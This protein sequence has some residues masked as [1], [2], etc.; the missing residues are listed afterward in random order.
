LGEQERAEHILESYLRTS[1][2]D[3]REFAWHYLWSICNAELTS[4][5]TEHGEVYDVAYAPAG[6]L[7]VTA[8]KD[9]TVRF[10]DPNDWRLKRTWPAHSSCVNAL[11]FT[12]DGRRIV[13]GSCDRT[14]AVWDART[15][16]LLRR[17]DNKQAKVSHVRFTP[18]GSQVVSGDF[19]DTCLRLWNVESGV[20]VA[21]FDNPTGSGNLGAVGFLDT[22]GRRLMSSAGDGL[23]VHDLANGL[24]E[25]KR[26]GTNQILRS[27][28]LSPDKRW[29]ARASSIPAATAGIGLDIELLR[30]DD[31]GE[32]LPAKRLTGIRAPIFALAFSGDGKL[33]ASGS[34]SGVVRLWDVDTASLRAAFTGHSAR[35]TAL[36]FAPDTSRL[37]SASADG[38]VKCWLLETAIQSMHLPVS[39]AVD[40]TTPRLAFTADGSLLLLA[41]RDG[42]QAW[43]TID[44]SSFSPASSPSWKSPNALACIADPERHDSCLIAL[45]HDSQLSL[46]DAWSDTPRRTT[47]SLPGDQLAFASNGGWLAVSHWDDVALR[48]VETLRIERRLPGITAVRPTPPLALSADGRWLAAADGGTSDMFVWDLMRQTTGAVTPIR[49]S[50]HS[51]L[52]DR[53][54]FSKDGRFLA[55]ASRDGTGRVWDIETGQERVTFFDHAGAVRAIAFAPDQRSI[56]TCAED[57]TI[58]VW[59][60]QTGIELLELPENAPGR[61]LD[62]AF[63]HR[64]DRLAALVQ[65]ADGR[66]VVTVWTAPRT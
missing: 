41:G 63:S 21:E 61:V 22:Q 20:L 38:T 15:G 35:I 3:L 50:G 55:S 62:L 13:T 29:L 34:D 24:A 7:I 32:A 47:E 1:E 2:D 36:R 14:L 58:H 4:L 37:L 5:A 59:D 43:S 18:D 53:L 65:R 16:E 45:L 51:L 6:D 46:W 27:A 64:S 30:L 12:P 52:V 60:P 28:A 44:W 23:R 54:T 33:L 42:V 19:E 49:F 10:W 57:G 56:A 26:F 31:E 25:L 66:C 9:G 17:I 48:N 40:A 8:G 11:D 39:I